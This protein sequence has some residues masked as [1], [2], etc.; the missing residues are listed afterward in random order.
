[1]FSSSFAS[2]LV[3]MV[4]DGQKS[5]CRVHPGLV[6]QG[7]YRILDDLSVA[8]RRCI[9][10]MY[11][12]FVSWIVLTALLLGAQALAPFRASYTYLL[13]FERVASTASAL[14]GFCLVVFDTMLRDVMASLDAVTGMKKKAVVTKTGVRKLCDAVQLMAVLTDLIMAALP[15]PVVMDPYLKTRVHLVRWLEWTFAGYMMTFLI[16]II[17]RGQNVYAHSLALTQGASTACALFFPFMPNDYCYVSLMALSFALFF[18]LFP[19][20]RRKR[21]AAAEAISKMVELRAAAE[22]SIVGVILALNAQGEAR[23]VIQAA[24]LITICTVVWSVFVFVFFMEPVARTFFAHRNKDPVWPFVVNSVLHVVVK[25]FF[26]GFIV[27][28]EESLFSRE[29]RRKQIDD[30]VRTFLGTGLESAGDCVGFVREHED[31]V[32]TVFSPRFLRMI[33]DDVEDHHDV[34]DDDHDA[35]A[36]D[37]KEVPRRGMPWSDDAHLRKLT[38]LMIDWNSRGHACFATRL[39]HLADV[40]GTD[41][42]DDD[43]D[44][45]A[46]TLDTAPLCCEHQRADGGFRLRRVSPDNLSFVVESEHVTSLIRRCVHLP[47]SSD[48]KLE[49]PTVIPCVVNSSPGPISIIVVPVDS[50]HKLLVLQDVVSSHIPS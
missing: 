47:H 9:K 41:D 20:L 17:D 33:H 36:S 28:C 7:S 42:D 31:R 44:D 12:S 48:K 3:R 27:A 24:A 16:E 23:R 8:D 38:G 25:L 37:E 35:A 45:S 40:M 18:V 43:D 29:S 6:R 26:S 39:R 11:V 30:A 2:S 5:T 32:T 49:I 19:R 10:V 13:P 21:R 50:T 1:M 4:R 15:V 22:T 46:V 34:V 14:I